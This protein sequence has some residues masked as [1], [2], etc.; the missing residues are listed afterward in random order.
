MPTT[1]F[2]DFTADQL[3]GKTVL[4]S[5]NI[6]S[7]ETQRLATIT[8]VTKT[9]FKISDADAYSYDINTG[10]RKGIGSS[11]MNWG[12]HDSCV[13][14]TNEEAQ[15]LRIKWINTKEKKRIKTLVT[16]KLP[17]LTLEQ[18]QSIE[19]IITP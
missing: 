11:R 17:T 3:K 7:R 19:K 18:L 15:A 9:S 5:A 6:D 14:V 12:V 2:S 1:N 10:R 4:N 16:E 13:L 8:H